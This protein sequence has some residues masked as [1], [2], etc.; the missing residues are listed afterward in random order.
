MVGRGSQLEWWAEVLNSNVLE[1]ESRTVE[2]DNQCK[3]WAVRAPF[4]VTHTSLLPP[5]VRVGAARV[6]AAESI[7]CDTRSQHVCTR[8]V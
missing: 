6:G 7:N 3:T 4:S 8:H 1:I 5:P 2:G